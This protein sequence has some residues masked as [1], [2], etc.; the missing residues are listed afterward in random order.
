MSKAARLKARPRRARRPPGEIQNPILVDP[1]PYDQRRN[2]D[3]SP[4]GNELLSVRR[5]PPRGGK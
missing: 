2:R 1:L 4:C 3:L 5:N